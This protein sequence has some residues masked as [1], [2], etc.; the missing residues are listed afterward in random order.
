MNGNF[1]IVPLYTTACACTRFTI[2]HFRTG[3]GTCHYE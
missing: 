1:G 3:R 2:T